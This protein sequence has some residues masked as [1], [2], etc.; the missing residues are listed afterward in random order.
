MPAGGVPETRCRILYTGLGRRIELRDYSSN[1]KI[2]SLK[3]TTRPEPTGLVPRKCGLA[4]DLNSSVPEFCAKGSNDFAGG[5][6]LV[7]TRPETEFRN[8]IAVKGA[9]EARRLYPVGS[10]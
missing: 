6:T 7:I 5:H 3:Y 2:R 10:R 8:S 4:R 1:E 9:S